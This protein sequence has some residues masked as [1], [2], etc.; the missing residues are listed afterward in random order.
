M[1]I[2]ELV[3]AF[4]DVP[5]L[6]AGIDPSGHLR[7]SADVGTR[8]D[9][10]RGL[11]TSPDAL[12]SFGGARASIGSGGE[13]PFALASGDTLTLTGPAGPYTV[14]FVPTDFAE[15]TQAS[16]EEIAAVINADPGT[17]ANG[18]Q[19]RTVGGQLVLQSIAE[20]STTSFE[21]TAGS[22]LGALGLTPGTTVTG[23]DTAVTVTLTGSYEGAGNRDLTFRPTVDGEIGTTPGL[24]VEVFD[25]NGSL[26]KTLDVGAGYQPGSEIELVDGVRVSFGLGTLSATHNDAFDATF[27]AASDSSDVL[28]ALGLGSF[29]EGTGLADIAVRSDIAADPSRLATSDDGSPGDNGALLR[30]LALQESV[31]SELGT[32]FGEFY[33]SVVGDVGFQIQSTEKSLELESFLVDSLVARRQQVSG[34]NM[35]EELVDMIRF[36]QAFGAAAQ[37]IQVVNSLNDEILNLV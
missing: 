11:D 21:V 16:A 33:G 28:V 19:A 26:V 18:L 36:E 13:G 7:L 2:G 35:D 37:F 5:G 14:T 30:L 9:F 15:I 24:Q 4:N 27:V 6:S 1:T 8:F 25:A 34:V 32:S 10:A 31:A 20:G 17:A 12:G 23:H 22:A 3:D 29:F